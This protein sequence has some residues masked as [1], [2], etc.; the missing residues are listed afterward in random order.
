M[1]EHLIEELSE[2]MVDGCTAP[3]Q[4]EISTGNYVHTHNHSFG[5]LRDAHLVDLKAHFGIHSL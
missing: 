2:V 3:N 5:K 1:I 4:L